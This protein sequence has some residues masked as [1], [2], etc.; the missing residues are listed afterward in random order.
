VSLVC[1]DELR[2]LAD[3]EKLMKRKLE[4]VVIPGF[5]PDPQCQAGTAA[6]ARK[7]PQPA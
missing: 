1:V 3:I 2:L 6:Q 5:E 4:Q 7:P